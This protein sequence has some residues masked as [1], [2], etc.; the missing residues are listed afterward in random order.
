[1]PSCRSKT[2]MNR[3]SIILK[4]LSNNIPLLTLVLLMLSPAAFAQHKIEREYAIKTAQVPA[5]AL[6]F[7][8]Q[9]FSKNRIRW[10]AEESQKGRSIE[11]KVKQDGTIY[12]IEFSEDGSIQDI[13]TLIAFSALSE[14]LREAIMKTLEADFTRI[15]IHKV[16][17]QWTGSA[18]T[19][20]QLLAKKKPEGEY[21]TRYELVMRGTENKHSSDYEVLLDEKGTLISKSKIIQK[22]SPHL[23]F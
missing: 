9:S 13:E 12:S 21:T 11:A 15:K 10:Y 3:R 14:D 22:D 5:Q 1:M 23:L 7:V 17:R 19:L 20:Q 18:A 6:K 8:N 4:K 16:Q 2:V